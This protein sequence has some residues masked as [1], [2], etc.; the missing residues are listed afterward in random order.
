M[1]Q[2][3]KV[4]VNSKFRKSWRH[5]YKRHIKARVFTTAEQVV[6]LRSGQY[7]FEQDYESFDS[8][9]TI[10]VVDNCAN[11]HIWNNKEEFSS[12]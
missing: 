9:G 8:D 7:T 5:Q 11:S 10:A 1:L 6:V 2:R 3:R 12:Y 4:V